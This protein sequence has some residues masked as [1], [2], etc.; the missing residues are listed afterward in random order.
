MISIV[1]KFK[2]LSFIKI[3][4]LSFSLV[5]S[6]FILLTLFIFGLESYYRMTGKLETLVLEM[7][8]FEYIAIVRSGEHLITSDADPQLLR[9]DDIYITN[10]TLDIEYSLYPGEV[11]LYYTTN[12]GEGFSSKNRAWFTKTDETIYKTDFFFPVK[13]NSIRIDPT[14]LAGNIIETNS[15]IIN[16]EKS[17][18]EYFKIT[19]S[20]IYYL[21]LYSFLLSSIFGLAVEILNKKLEK[22]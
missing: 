15:I 1:N 4:L 11:T 17:F 22:N 9:T 20:R 10:I 7:T 8:D 2:N 18:F 3:I 5:I 14:D 6:T 21:F 19:P 16:E 13:T 12:E